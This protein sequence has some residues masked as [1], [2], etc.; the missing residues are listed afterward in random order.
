MARS[1]EMARSLGFALVK[2]AVLLAVLLV[3]KPAK[4]EATAQAQKLS[5]LSEW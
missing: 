1:E 4:D 5:P 2:A 3:P